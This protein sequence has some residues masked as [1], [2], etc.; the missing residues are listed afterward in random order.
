MRTI[1]SWLLL[2]QAFLLHAQQTFSVTD[3]LPVTWNGLKAGYTITSESEKEVGKKGDFSRY[4]IYFWLTNTG[5]EARILY[6]K[7]GNNGHTGSLSNIIA[8]FKCSNATGARLT[9]KNA[10]MELQPCRLDA[11]IE[12][13]D[14]NSDKTITQSVQANIGYW[15]RPG[16]TVSKTYPMIFPLNERPVVTVSFFP[17]NGSQAGILFNDQPDNNENRQFVRLRNSGAGTYLNNQDG[18]LH[19]SPAENGWWSADWEILPVPGSGSFV[20]R[21]RWKN[22]Y[23]CSGTQVTLCDNSGTAAAHWILEE[24]SGNSTYIIR[25][26]TDRAR[27]IFRNGQLT[28]SNSYNSNDTQSTWIIEK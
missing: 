12:T 25:N 18:A 14:P 20:I 5:T 9:N 26:E 27:L 19:C 24:V 1:F 3:S 28:C 16:E 23:L 13:K 7:P 17:E 4:K 6:R 10:S 15:I 8:L 2:L 11:S 22:N 21:N